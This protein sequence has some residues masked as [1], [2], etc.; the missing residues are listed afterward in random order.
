ME[1][2]ARVSVRRDEAEAIAMAGGEPRGCW[3]LSGLIG[4]RR[5][6]SGSMERHGRRGAVNARYRSP[7]IPRKS[8]AEAAGR[9]PGANKALMREA[10]GQPGHEGGNVSR[11]LPSRVQKRLVTCPRFDGSE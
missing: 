6:V 3:L 4:V 7:S 1:A 5:M 10:G 2:C 8:R 11:R 9:G